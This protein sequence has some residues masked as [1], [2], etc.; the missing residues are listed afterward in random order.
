LD[1]PDGTREDAEAWLLERW[2]DGGREEWEAQ[3]SKVAS[4]GKKK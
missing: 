3:A 2:S 4:K 1:N